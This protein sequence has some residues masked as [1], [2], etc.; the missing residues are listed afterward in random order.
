MPYVCPSKYFAGNFLNISSD[1]FE[2]FLLSKNKL[3]N[4]NNFNSFYIKTVKYYIPIIKLTFEMLKPGQARI[5]DEFIP[6]FLR[7]RPLKFH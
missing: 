7:D 1:C 4:C 5:C 2:S 3:R 6:L